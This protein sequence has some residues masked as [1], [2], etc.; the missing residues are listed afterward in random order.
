[1]AFTTGTDESRRQLEAT[2]RR[3][4]SNAPSPEPVEQKR[5]QIQDGIPERTRTLSSRHRQHQSRIPT[6]AENFGLARAGSDARRRRPRRSCG[7]TGNR[8]R[9]R[10]G[11]E[12]GRGPGGAAARAGEVWMRSVRGSAGRVVVGV[13][14]R[15]A[16]EIMWTRLQLRAFVWSLEAVEI[17]GDAIL[18]ALW[19]LMRRGIVR[20]R[21]RR[22]G[23]ESYR[24]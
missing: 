9:R 4:R 6:S 22:H 16:A 5:R 12:P 10:V 11:V 7:L 15:A 14:D 3:R 23:R 8:W 17:V 19:E 20:E 18:H 21:P 2:M 13:R 1:M 24:R